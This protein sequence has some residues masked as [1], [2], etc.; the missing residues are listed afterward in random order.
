MDNYGLQ[1]QLIN[2]E[3]DYSNAIINKESLLYIAKNID[4]IFQK[5]KSIYEE[6]RIKNEQLKTEYKNH[7]FKDRHSKLQYSLK[8]KDI[9][10]SE[11][12][13]YEALEI[14]VKDGKFDNIE[15]FNIILELDYSRGKGDNLTKLE[16]TFKLVFK[17]Y[18]I[19]FTRK[20][21]YNDLLMQQ[22]EESINNSL[23]QLNTLNTVFCTKE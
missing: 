4:S 9:Y 10:C 12:E 14:A 15:Y 17:P 22:V 20:S 7:D 5:M 16:N 19:T 13:S 21:N 23:K 8:L 3:F 1:E 18:E 6:D 2:N 11:I